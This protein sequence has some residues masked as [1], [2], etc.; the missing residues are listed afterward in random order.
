MEM[1][2]LNSL[3]QLRIRKHAISCELGNILERR[4]EITSAEGDPCAWLHDVVLESLDYTSGSMQ[5]PVA[6]L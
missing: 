4:G 6:C 5:G 2:K 1:D 3:I